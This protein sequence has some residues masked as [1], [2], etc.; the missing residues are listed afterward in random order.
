M[1]KKI[2]ITSVI[3]ALVHFALTISLMLF[4]ISTGMEAF[5]NPDHH[6]S[7]IERFSG[8][9]VKVLMQ[10]VMSLWTPWMSKNMPNMVEWV[11]VIANSLLWGF[12]I[13]LIIHILAL[14]KRKESGKRKL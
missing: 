11:L 13:V 10:P 3:V 8:S 4:A 6:I 1:N 12:A 7:G 14:M 9:L 2:I 5:N